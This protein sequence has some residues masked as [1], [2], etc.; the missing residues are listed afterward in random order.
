MKMLRILLMFVFSASF[1]LAISSTVA[2]V[3]P[4]YTYVYGNV[5]DVKTNEGI[6]GVRVTALC[7]ETSDTNFD[8]NTDSNGDYVITPLECSIGHTVRVTVTKEDV[9]L[10][11]D[12]GIVEDCNDELGMCNSHVHVGISNIKIGIPEYPLAILPV[13]LAMMTF[14]LVSR[15][16]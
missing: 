11:S 14:G 5:Y 4:Q 15:R 10:G 8:P 2:A 7:I 13:M 12:E 6:V 1:V 16:F 9:V 3:Q